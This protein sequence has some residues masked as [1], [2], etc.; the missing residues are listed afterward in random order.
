MFLERDCKCVYMRWPSWL[1]RSKN[2]RTFRRVTTDC[3]EAVYWNGAVNCTHSVREI[4]LSGAVIRTDL[5]WGPGTLI[6]MMFRP[7]KREET[8]KPDLAMGLW[9]RV[10]RRHAEGFCVQF[11]FLDRKETLLFRRFLEMAV[12]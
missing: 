3:L 8:G 6:Y 4:S 5:N 10:I 9:G 12:E 1:S 2:R 11:V 7:V